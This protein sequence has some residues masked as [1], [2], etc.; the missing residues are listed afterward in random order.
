MLAQAVQIHRSQPP[1][2]RE[3][4]IVGKASR[5]VAVGRGGGGVNERRAMLRAPIQQPQRQPEIGGDDEIAVGCRRVGNCTEMN[6][7][8]ELSPIEPTL[9]IGGSNYV[10]ELTL[11]QVAPLAPT[12]EPVAD[13]NVGASPLIE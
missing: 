7:G 12:L 13:G 9:Q 11:L 8:I 10:R 3:R 4:A 5:P 1:E 6:D 2:R